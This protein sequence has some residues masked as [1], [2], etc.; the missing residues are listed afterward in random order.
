ML[1]R[2]MNLRSE[3]REREGNPLGLMNQFQ[4]NPFTRSPSISTRVRRWETLALTLS[5][6]A[7]MLPTLW[8]WSKKT[9][10]GTETRNFW[11]GR[12]VH[13]KSGSSFPSGNQG[14]WSPNELTVGQ[15]LC[16]KAFV[17]HRK[18]LRDHEGPLGSFKF[19]LAAGV[20]LTGHTPFH[21]GGQ[22]KWTQ[23]LYHSHG[24]GYCGG[25]EITRA[26]YRGE[27]GQRLWGQLDLS[28]N[29]LI[30]YSHLTWACNLTSLWLSLLSFIE[31]SN[32]TNLN[33]LLKWLIKWCIQST[34]HSVWDMVNSATL[35]YSASFWILLIIKRPPSLRY[36]M[37]IW[38]K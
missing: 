7:L 6:S 26:P 13:Q 31:G 30:I 9:D 8:V 25:L 1:K 23:G 18:V 32:T 4:K 34:Q 27:T 24:L 5:T 12:S 3:S 17:V 14:C 38:Q 36:L 29:S 20:L 2:H 19:T 33:N 10:S 35:N 22:A 15:A 37:A 16:S 28:L 11:L 21:S